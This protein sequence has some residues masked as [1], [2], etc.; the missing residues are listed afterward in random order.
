MVAVERAEP[1]PELPVYQPTVFAEPFAS[2]VA[3]PSGEPETL[4][5][6]WA[7]VKGPAPPKA[8]ALNPA[9]GAV[10]AA[11]ELVMERLAALSVWI[12]MTPPET[13]DGVEVPVMESIFF[14]S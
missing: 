7:A 6:G 12:V 14:K 3:L 10:P 5:G 11:F 9:A 2:D 1:G 4:S 8:G 13:V